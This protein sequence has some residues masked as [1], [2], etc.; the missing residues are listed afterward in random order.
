MNTEGQRDKGHL[1][2]TRDRVLRRIIAEIVDGLAHGFFDLR[3]SC[4]LIGHGR[5]RLVLHAG[6]TYQFVIPAGDCERADGSDALQCG[7]REDI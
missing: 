7:S 2:S 6:K 4:E 5:R 1:A 3:V